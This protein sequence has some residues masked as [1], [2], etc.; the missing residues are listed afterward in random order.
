MCQGLAPCKST[1][2]TNPYGGYFTFPQF[3][4]GIDILHGPWEKNYHSGE[5]QVKTSDTALHHPQTPVKTISQN[6]Y[7]SGKDGIKKYNS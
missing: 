5:G 2:S 3:V 4:T 6:Q 7:I 1:V